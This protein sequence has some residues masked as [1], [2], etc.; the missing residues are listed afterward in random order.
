[1]IVP[2]VEAVTKR[3]PTEAGKY[4]PVER[5]NSEADKWPHGV[6]RYCIAHGCMAWR[7]GK[8]DGTFRLGY[9]GVAGLP[10]GQK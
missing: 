9:C 1:M 8:S 5:V 6:G 4:V 7:W 2:P 3:C 10:M